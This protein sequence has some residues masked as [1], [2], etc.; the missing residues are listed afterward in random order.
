M[1]KELC[2]ALSICFIATT[3]AHAQFS[4]T[5]YYAFPAGS[6]GGPFYSQSSGVANNWMLTFRRDTLLTREAFVTVSDPAVLTLDGGSLVNGL[7]H[8][9]RVEVTSVAPASGPFEFSFSLTLG[10]PSSSRAYY[11]VNGTQFA[12]SG[13]GGSQAISLAAGD[14]FGFAVDIGPQLIANQIRAEAILRISNFSAPV[15]EPGSVLLI[16]AGA[17]CLAVAR[18]ALLSRARMAN[19]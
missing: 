12:L 17:A 7:G 6:G 1:K 8:F 11:L 4:G 3:A 19:D 16:G 13:A 14:R 9:S 10:T 18:R 2:L 5:G 15:P